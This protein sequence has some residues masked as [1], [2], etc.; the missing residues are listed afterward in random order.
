MRLFN[1]RVSIESHRK[2]KNRD[3]K[4]LVLLPIHCGF[5]FVYEHLSFCAGNDFQRPQRRRDEVDN[6]PG[7]TD[8]RNGVSSEWE[9]DERGFNYLCQSA[10]GMHNPMALAYTYRARDDR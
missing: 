8:M 5:H 4:I 3:N 10:D 9:S 2:E 6:N 7:F 1:H